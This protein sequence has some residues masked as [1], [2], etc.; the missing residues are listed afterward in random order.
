MVARMAFRPLLHVLQG[1]RK[2]RSWADLK[3]LLR[4]RLFPAT[5]TRANGEDPLPPLLFRMAT[6]Y[7]MSQAIYVAAK[8]GIADLLADGPQSF[9]A[10]AVAT[11][12]DARSMFRLLRALSSVN[13][14]SQEDT[15]CFALSRLSEALRSD[16]PGS[17]RASDHGR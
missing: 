7:W 5:T 9:A 8:L 13:V 4:D 6:A 2:T 17:L 15:D 10:L 14:F 16:V 1:A 3:L 11:R 12:S